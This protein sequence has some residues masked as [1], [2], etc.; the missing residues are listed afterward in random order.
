MYIFELF[1]MTFNKVDRVAYCDHIFWNILFLFLA[2]HSHKSYHAM[3]L[4]PTWE[5]EQNVSE[6]MIT[7]SNSIYFV[8]R[9]WEKF[10]NIQ[11]LHFG[12][13]IPFTKILLK[14]LKKNVT[15]HWGKIIGSRSLNNRIN[16]TNF[17]CFPTFSTNN[18]F[19]TSDLACNWHVFVSLATSLLPLY[20]YELI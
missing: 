14:P 9:H 12:G 17:K 20:A 11:C 2:P 15:F 10:K 19:L 16:Y 13:K 8:K 5:G 3:I 6:N 18:K 1:P 4:H 7:V